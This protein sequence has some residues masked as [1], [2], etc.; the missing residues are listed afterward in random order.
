MPISEIGTA[1]L[2]MIVAWMLCRN[3]KITSTTSNTASTSSNST[4]WTEARMPVVRS[5]STVTFRPDGSA[6]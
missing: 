2:A 3:R 6:A 1:R 4:S 5:L